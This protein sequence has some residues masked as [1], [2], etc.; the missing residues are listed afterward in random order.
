MLKS[1]PKLQKTL[2]SGFEVLV[3]CVV[4]EQRAEIS[5]RCVQNWRNA[6]IAARE[7]M[8]RGEVPVGGFSVYTEHK[9]N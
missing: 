4:K 8:A 7:A 1:R 3:L 9:P 5:D 2:N 6:E